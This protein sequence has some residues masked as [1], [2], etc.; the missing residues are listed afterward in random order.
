MSANTNDPANPEEDLRARFEK[1]KVV[2]LSRDGEPQPIRAGI[3]REVLDGAATARTPLRCLH[4]KGAKFDEA[5]DLSHVGEGD[6]ASW[7]RM[8]LEDCHLDELLLAGARLRSLTLTDC[9]ITAIAGEG[10]RVADGLQITG[11]SS[12]EGSTGTGV[13]GEP[14]CTVN[15]SGAT[16]GGT[17]RVSES[18]FCLPATERGRHPFLERRRYALNLGGA[19]IGG[20]LTLLPGLNASGGVSIHSARVG[21]HVWAC[22]I[23]ATAAD[24]AA[25]MA[26]GAEIGGFLA[27]HAFE[28]PV[29][30]IQRSA[31]RGSVSLA[32][33]N[34]R[35]SVTLDGAHLLSNDLAPNLDFRLATIQGDLSLGVRVDGLMTFEGA[36][37]GGSLA[38]STPERPLELD[39]S[40]SSAPEL[41]LRNAIVER[42]LSVGRIIALTEEGQALDERLRKALLANLDHIV[43]ARRRT[44]SF[45]PGWLLVELTFHVDGVQTIASVLWDGRSRFVPLPGKSAPIHSL[46]ASGALRIG[47]ERAAVDYLEFFCSHV[48]GDAGPFLLVQSADD[49]RL[50]GARP[51]TTVAPIAIQQGGQGYVATTHVI[52]GEQLFKAQFRIEHNGNVVMLEDTPL[53]PIQPTA[54]YRAPF[55][56]VLSGVAGAEAPGDPAAPWQPLA[57]DAIASGLRQSLGRSI[58]ATWPRAHVNLEGCSIGTLD[59]LG[60]RAWGLNILTSLNGIAINRVI[61][62]QPASRSAALARMEE[63][64]LRVPAWL[65]TVAT[66]IAM[67]LRAAVWFVRPVVW[68]LKGLVRPIVAPMARAVRSRRKRPRP[69]FVMRTQY[70]GAAMFDGLV[71]REWQWRLWWLSLQYRNFEPSGTEFSEQVYSELARVY[72]HQGHT[73]EATRLLSERLTLERR[74][75]ASLLM[76]PLL[77]FWWLGFDYGL[78]PRRAVVTAVVAMLAG[79]WAVAWANNRELLVV[80]TLPAATLAV[81]RA[82]PG[83]A[84]MSIVTGTPIGDATSVQTL[85]PC[86]D[87]I[88]PVLYAADVFIPLL[89]LRQ[90]QRCQVRAHD[91]SRDPHAWVDGDSYWNANI[92]SLDRMRRDPRVWSFLH[93]LYAL[94]GAIVTSLVVLT[95]SG[96]TERA[97]FRR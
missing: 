74:L 45:Y 93:A 18:A 19:R 27:F 51:E 60:G 58:D 87:A 82:N 8:T 24:E 56:Q 21:G 25:F 61:K 42:T 34:V 14:A 3:L 68:L 1:G 41:V 29:S 50:V 66:L 37:I 38:L 86:A 85:I 17:V 81:Q 71:H 77:W 70:A 90:E 91:A 94:L 69:P 63:A 10:V 11:L 12:N 55:R 89:D 16:V 13:D 47:N 49:P 32:A 88:V 73:E 65:A 96:V 2:D 59:D 28:H 20:D 36:R 95:V 46:N 31:L 43:S 84:A 62:W 67:V 23:Q 15:L 97:L 39:F 79:G 30:G 22:G 4:L 54:L 64:A 40:G 7:L 9:R 57:V 5:L 26:Q 35:G 75:R 53:G 76:K 33:G 44:L 83:G 92:E 72:Q 6:E 48:W 52:Y 78:S 80:D